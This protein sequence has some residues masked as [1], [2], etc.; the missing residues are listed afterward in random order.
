MRFLRLSVA[1][2]ALSAGLASG[3]DA[4]GVTNFHQVNDHVFRGAQPSADGFKNLSKLGIKTILDLRDEPDLVRAEQHVVEATGMRFVSIPMHGMSAPSE[5][6]LAKAL[7]I[8]N[9][10]SAGPV[11]VHCRRG[12]DRTGTV[13]A[14][15]RI[16]AEHWQNDKA[17]IEA[18]A[19][20]MSW[21][22]FAMHRCIRD[23]RAASATAVAA[24][25]QQ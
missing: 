20:G 25:T 2:W 22:E 7:A 11:F 13:I 17:L 4:P 5:A 14:C 3:P 21:T 9:D 6:Q 15:Y 8:L 24:T 12:A 18:K 19:F 10:V 1:L 16:S 23:Y